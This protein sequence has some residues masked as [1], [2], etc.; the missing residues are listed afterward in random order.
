MACNENAAVAEQQLGSTELLSLL[1]LLWT[2]WHMVPKFVTWLKQSSFHLVLNSLVFV[3]FLLCFQNF[4][5]YENDWL[6]CS[7][8][9]AVHYS[10]EQA[11][12]MVIDDQSSNVLIA[13]SDSG[14][15]WNFLCWLYHEWIVNKC[16][17]LNMCI[18]STVWHQNQLLYPNKQTHLVLHLVIFELMCGWIRLDEQLRRHSSLK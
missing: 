8:C 17:T 16:K 11:V 9:A 5:T 3:W 10:M 6:S 14:S 1:N 7:Q 15:V 2:K 4:L 18:P 13:D 12:S